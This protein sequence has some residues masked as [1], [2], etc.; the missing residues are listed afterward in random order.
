MKSM[1]KRKRIFLSISLGL[2]LVRA[3][4]H[5]DDM[6]VNNNELSVTLKSRHIYE[7]DVSSDSGSISLTESQIGFFKEFKI[8]R[9]PLVTGLKF[10]HTDINDSVRMPLPTKLV[11]QELLLGVKFPAPYLDSDRYFIGVDIFPSMYRD[12]WQWKS[13]SFRIPS[14]IYLIYRE[15]ER[16]VLVGGFTV[17]PGFDTTVFPILGFIYQPNDQL[18]FNFAS[19]NPSVTYKINERL[20]VLGE[21]EFVVDEYEVDR[22]AQRNVVLKF[23]EYSAGVGLNYHFNESCAV[24][25]STGAVL[26]RQIEY[27]DEVGKLAPDTGLY[28]DI[29]LTLKF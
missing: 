9:L 29:R 20:S 13:S 26:G 6:P 3:T 22:G 2:C 12:D 16:F 28:S 23:K 21:L 10:K 7:S 1:M 4:T 19:D 18:K 8:D 15:S 14:R 17:R 27:E 25:V 5:A 11:G 24:K